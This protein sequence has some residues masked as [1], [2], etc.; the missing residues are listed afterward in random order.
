M[1]SIY[2]DKGIRLV[3][4][5]TITKDIRKNSNYEI[6]LFIKYNNRS[7]YHGIL[8]KDIPESK[9]KIKH[10]YYCRYIEKYGRLL[11]IDKIKKFNY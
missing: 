1:L 5:K 8:E 4:R 6:F 11:S 3:S 9:I 7:G 10:Q 2:S